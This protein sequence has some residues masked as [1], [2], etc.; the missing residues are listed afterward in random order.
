MEGTGSNPPSIVKSG[1]ST[2]EDLMPKEP[3]VAV[4]LV[5]K[6]SELT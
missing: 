3:N 4:V 1:I 6:T 2:I 5:H